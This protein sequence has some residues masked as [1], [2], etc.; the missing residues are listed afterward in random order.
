VN[1]LQL[2][3]VIVGA[4]AVTAVAQRRSAQPA[5]VITVVALAASF[6]PGIPRLQ[7][8]SDVV[9]GVVLPPLLYSAAVGFSVQAFFRKLGSILVL[10]VGL[11][12]VTSLAVGAVGSWAVASLTT[13]SAIVLGAVVAPPDAVSA[14]AIGRELGLRK[15]VLS[16][17]TGESLVNDAA[18]LTIFSIAVASVSGAHTSIDNPVLLFAYSAAVGIASG[19][20]LAIVALWIRRLLRNPGLEVVLGLVVPFA[21]YMLAEELEASGVLAVVAAG[22]VIGTLSVRFDYETR[23]QERTVWGALDVLLE[24][25]VFAYMGL[26]LRFVIDDLQDAHA[27]VW[28]TFGAGLLILAVVI[29]VRP[30]WMFLTL[31]GGV[32][33]EDSPDDPKVIRMQQRIAR[34]NAHRLARG[35]R[36]PRERRPE[37]LTLREAVVVAWT[38][39]RGVVTLAAA[40]G[41]PLTVHG[42]GP[43]PGRPEIQAIAFLVAVGTLLLQGATLPWLIRHLDIEDPGEADLARERR[44]AVEL[45]AHRAQAAVFEKFLADPPPGIDPAFVERAGERFARQREAASEAA[46]DAEGKSAAAEAMKTLTEDVIAEQRRA[47]VEGLVRDE[48][49]DDAV[50]DYLEQIDLQ[51]AAIVSRFRSRL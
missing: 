24:A 9:L 40:A 2:V 13:G 34:E 7:L 3:L 5:L 32:V 50:R 30:L 45:V 49:D 14:V 38:G 19:F 47:V 10:G 8:D 1:G 6:I 44:R 22:F 15:R 26:Q 41:I 39:M 37:P 16:V 43:F 42:G 31:G 17:L 12:V 51:E 25:F 20:V 46:L 28:S 29:V 23:L 4:I 27:S 11:V 33:V 48:L 21:A 35:R 18:A 36:A